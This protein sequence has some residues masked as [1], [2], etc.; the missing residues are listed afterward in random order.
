MH[1]ATS[2][3]TNFGEVVPASWP[4]TRPP[5]HCHAVETIVVV[6]VKYGRKFNKTLGNTELLI[7]GLRPA[8]FIFTFDIEPN[9]LIKNNAKH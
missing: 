8:A 3:W 9:P 7:L 2:K 6:W 5:I 4:E 1:I